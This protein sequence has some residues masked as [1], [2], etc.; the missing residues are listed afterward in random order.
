MIRR[1]LFYKLQEHLSKKEFSIITGARQTGKTTLLKQLAEDCR[2]AGDPTIFLNLENR[3]ILADLDENPLNLLK[4]L[5]ESD[6]RVIV[7]IDEIQYLGDPSHFLKLIFDD[8]HQKIKIVATGSSAFYMYDRF[9]DSL[10]GRKRVFQLFTCSFREYLELGGKPDLLAELDRIISTKGSKS[11]EIDYLR[12]EWENYMLYGGYPSVITEPDKEEKVNRLKE[13]RDSYIKRDIQESGVANESAFYQLFRILASQTGSLVNVN[14]LSSTLR[15][16]HETVSSYIHVMRKCFH[17]SLVSPFYSNLRKELVKMP[18]VFV[19]DNGM[20]NCLLNNFKPL[21]QRVDRGELWENQV[22]R[23][24]IDRHGIEEVRFWRTSAG[25]EVDFVVPDI[26]VP[27]AYEAKV[28]QHLINRKKYKIFEEN[29]P[30]IKMEFLWLYP[31]DED[32]FR[33]IPLSD[34]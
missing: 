22:C 21:S 14:E 27:V 13:I 29:Y 18:K 34:R 3:G 24:L 32:F 9:R 8:H 17:V 12:I 16:K 28:D 1:K 33:R 5:P 11:T 10:A 2:Q 6:R 15:I 31:F 25:N 19:L 23:L 30:D 7:F 20:R 4:Y 26:A